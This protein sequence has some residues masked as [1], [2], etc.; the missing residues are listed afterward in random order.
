MAGAIIEG[1]DGVLLVRNR[2]RD[3]SVDWSTPGGVID[4]G[5]TVVEGLTREVQEETGL[6]V[7]GWEGPLYE[8]EAVAAGMGWHLRVEVHRAVAYEGELVVDDPDGIVDDV[9]FVPLDLCGEQLAAAWVPTHEPLLA[10]LEDRTA[11]RTY[12]YV[13]AGESRASMT[14]TRQ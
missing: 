11:G 2:R 8:V 13:I 10:W 14:I 4:E 7:T 1:P 5:E 12:R 9:R 3:G 6:R